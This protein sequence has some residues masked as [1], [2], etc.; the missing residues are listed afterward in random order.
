MLLSRQQNV[1]IH[2]DTKIANRCF[3]N[4]TQSRYFVKRVTNQK[5]FRRKLRRFN[6][7]NA[8]YHSI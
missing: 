8:L 6:S 2:L 7:G 4:V 3:E 1:G 5:F